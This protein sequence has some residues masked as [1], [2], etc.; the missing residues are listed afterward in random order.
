M[1]NKQK[2]PRR[3][4]SIIVPLNA[5][6]TRANRQRNKKLYYLI[7]WLRYNLLRG[8][9]YYR[10]EPQDSPR[11]MPYGAYR[12]LAP[13]QQKLDD[14]IS[15]SAMTDFLAR[16]E[17]EA[18]APA[19]HLIEHKTNG[20]DVVLPPIGISKAA[21]RPLSGDIPKKGTEIDLFHTPYFARQMLSAPLDKPVHEYPV[22]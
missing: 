17:A 7:R 9:N 20:V 21:P 13:L 5:P 10:I 18:I 19:V 15:G 22:D 16:M 11:S 4:I 12:L 6:Y 1:S 3:T 8:N 2:R 14:F